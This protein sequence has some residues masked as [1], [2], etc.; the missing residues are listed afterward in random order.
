M[1]PQDFYR[2][3][4]LGHLVG[5]DDAPANGLGTDWQNY[6]AGMGKSVVDNLRGLQQVG[7]GLASHLPL[8]GD[9]A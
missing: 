6:A 5:L 8:V 4:G 2:Q 3:A 9:R 7:A 1:L